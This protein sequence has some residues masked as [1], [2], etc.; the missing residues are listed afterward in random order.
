MEFVNATPFPARFLAG[1]TGDREMVGVA[2]C[3]VTYRVADDGGLVPAEPEAAWPV[4]EKP[5]AFEGVSFV[6]ELD[7]RKQ[8]VDVLVFGS[9]VAP[10]GEPTQEATVAIESGR[11]RFRLRAVGDRRWERS[12]TGRLRPSPPEPFVEMPFANDRAFGGVALYRGEPMPHALNPEGRGFYVDKAHARGGPLPNLE[13]IEAP[14][15][16][17]RDWPRPAC[18]FRPS[19]VVAYEAGEDVLDFAMRAAHLVLSPAVE[20]L[21]ARPEDLGDRLVLSGFSAQG[22]IA[23]PLPPLRGPALRAC[24]GPARSRFAAALSA[25]VVL[26]AE[27]AVVATYVARFRFLFR[28]LEKRSAELVWPGPHAVPPLA[29]GGHHGRA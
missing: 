13:R 23:L 2:T 24:V 17:W 9:V 1:S 20:D 6:S 28:A 11:L 14:I 19:G 25:L 5:H 15:G 21:V 8:G 16:H 18:P 3:K 22:P 27:R 26:L 10:G 12:F 29:E 7:Y 4:F